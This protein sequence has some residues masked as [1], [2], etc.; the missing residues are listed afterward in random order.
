[1]NILVTGGAGFIG[2]YI[3]RLLLKQGHDVVVL[4]DLSTG[5]YENVREI[6]DGRHFRL[7]VDKVPSVNWKVIFMGKDFTPATSSQR[8]W[9]STRASCGFS[10]RHRL[11]NSESGSRKRYF[12]FS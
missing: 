6:D 10:S 2:S 9:F 1:M 7:I 5:R 3:C 12:T 11:R 4:D 8:V